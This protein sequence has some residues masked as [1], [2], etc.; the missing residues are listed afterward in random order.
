[1]DQVNSSSTEYNI[2]EALRLRGELDLRAFQRTMSVIVDRHE[3]LRALRP[4]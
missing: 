4:S 3:I 1:M 2:P